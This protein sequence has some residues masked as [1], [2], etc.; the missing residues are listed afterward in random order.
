MNLLDVTDP[1]N[2]PTVTLD[3]Q[4]GV[5]S[6]VGPIPGGG[7]LVWRLRG[8]E[9]GRYTLRFDVAGAAV[10]KELVVSDR[11]ERVSAVRTASAWTT[12]LLHPA[13]SRLPSDLPI[14][15]IEILYPVVDSYIY[16]ADYWVLYFF[17]ISMLAALVV[18]P[19]FGVKF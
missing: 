16:G 12:Q 14:T 19:V 17:V 3:P 5:T 9:P 4:P 8:D 6:E 7:S 2:T 13:E 10:E 18:K 15:S 1:G 11:L